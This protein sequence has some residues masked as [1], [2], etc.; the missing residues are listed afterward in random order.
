MI[1]PLLPEH[2]E[3]IFQGKKIFC[4]YTG[5]GTPKLHIGNKLLFY[6]SGGI[7]EIRGE[8]TITD[9][10]FLTIEEILEKYKEHLFITPSELVSYSKKWE[11]P[12]NRKL[13]VLTL[14]SVKRYPKPVKV[15]KSVTMTGLGLNKRFYQKILSEVSA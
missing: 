10:E 9:V 5:K 12:E 4:K 8:G 6:A 11:R 15:S 1:Y 14:K 13:L 3:R 2:I 7:Y